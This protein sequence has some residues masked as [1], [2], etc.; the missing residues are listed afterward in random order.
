ML[1][2]LKKSI[3]LMSVVEFAGVELKRSGTRHVGLCPFHTE[4]TPS[5]YIFPDNHFKCFGCGVHG[6][7]IDFIQKL[8]GLSFPDALR[9]LGIEQGELTPE[10]RRDIAKRKH[11]AKLKR[12]FRDW[13]QR[14]GTHISNLWHK[15]KRLMVAGI[16]LDDLELHTS[17]FHMLP[18]WEHHRNILI[19][20]TDEE[21]FELYKEARNGKFRL[22]EAA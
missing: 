13:E 6:D 18:V 3:D 22:R 17:L 2:K 7:S 21:K 1:A 14:Y 11:R 12:Q 20:G 16:P 5:F 10:V 8:H 9:H 19:S 4:K 15:T